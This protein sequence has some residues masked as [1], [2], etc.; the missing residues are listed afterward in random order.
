MVEILRK[1]RSGKK[2]FESKDVISSL[3]D[4]ILG[5]ILSF[6]PTKNAVATT[7]VSSRWKNLY[8]LCTSLDFDDSVSVPVSSR[9]DLGNARR[10]MVSF[11][12]FVKEMLTQFNKSDI[13][14]FRLKCGNDIEYSLLYEWI[15]A[16]FL[17]KVV[18]LELSID[19]PMSCVLQVSQLT[20][21]NLVVLN[22]DCKFILRVPRSVTFPS[23]K[24]LFFKEVKF[25]GNRSIR[26]IADSEVF[27]LD[28]T[29]LNGILDGCPLLEEL[30]IDG[31]DWNGG[32]LYFSN[33]LLKRLTLN[34]G[35]TGPID[36]LNGSMV[37]ID[38]PSLVYF[39]YSQ[40]LAEWYDFRNMKSLLEAHLVICFN[41]DDYE[42]EQDLC[43]VILDLINGVCCCRSLHLSSQCLEVLLV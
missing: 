41:D 22:L 39:Y 29:D 4:D 38:L 21:Q 2:S 6:L 43:N 36:Q 31:C 35:L 16:A 7:A 15:R 25:H 11:K 20:C 8:K 27:S 30:V 26:F 28:Y 40:C 1:S 42:D 5:R 33:P 12:R 32:D 19:M 10:D 3:P 24:V 37:H 9:D 14:K 17:H 34:D 23:L 18:Q 13:T